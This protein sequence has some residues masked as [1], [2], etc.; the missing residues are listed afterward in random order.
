MHPLA[1]RRCLA[2]LTDCVG[3]LGVAA[4]TLPV[5]VLVVTTTDL[6]RVPLFGHL[7]S[8]VPPAIATVLAARAEAGPHRATWGKR[9]QGLEVVGRDG[10]AMSL[11]E[12]LGR[13]AL[14]IFVPWQLG[15]LTAIGAAWGGFEE[16]DPLTLASS[17][18][19]YTV[20]GVH[21][22]TGLRGTGRGVHDLLAGSRV[23]AVAPARA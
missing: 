1:S 3:Y 15:H 16:R 5:G 21:A 12:A 22:W 14:K 4:A 2:H 13:N 8:T 6:G 10:G 19:V 18:A 9:R 20:I 17:I 11:G 23:T 7:V